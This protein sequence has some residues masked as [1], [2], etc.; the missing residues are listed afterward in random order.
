MKIRLRQSLFFAEVII[1]ALWPF[2]MYITFGGIFAVGLIYT[3][4]LEIGRS[5]TGGTAGMLLFVGVILLGLAAIW[6]FCVVAISYLKDGPEGVLRK[7]RV[8]YTGALLGFL[9]L[10]FMVYLLALNPRS[11]GQFYFS[12]L[13]VL[14]PCAHLWLEIIFARRQQDN[15]TAS[16]SKAL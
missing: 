13:P 4:L 3:S 5:G 1:L 14:I 15:T 16:I 2:Y 10:T 7:R 9:P 6:K 8:F 11:L 12:G